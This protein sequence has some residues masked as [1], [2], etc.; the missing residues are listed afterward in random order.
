MASEKTSCGSIRNELLELFRTALTVSFPS[1]SA[2]PVVAACNNAKNGDYQCNNA[3]ALFGKLK[4]T[5]SAPKAPRDVATAIVGALPAN[6]LIAET[7][8]AGP[9][10]INIRLS[11]DSLSTRL[12]EMLVK[13]LASWAPTGYIGK[14]VVIDFSSPNVAKEMHVG[15]LR[16]TIIGDTL[17]RIFEYCGAD[18]LRLNHVGDWGTQF[19]ML[20]EH[21]ADAR[22]LRVA[23]GGEDK[24]MDEDVADL[25]ELYRAA[26]KRFDEEEEFK[27]RAREAVTRLQSGD[28]ESLASWQRICAASR[29]EFE[30]IYSRLGVTLQERGESFY[31]PMLKDVVEELKA[32]GVATI[33]NGAACVFV[34]GQSVPL[35]VQKSDGGFGYASTD[36]AAIKHRLNEE[37]ADWIIYVTDVGQSQHFELV[38]AAAKK[39]GWLVDGSGP[40]VSHVGFGLVLG[41][42]GKRF[43]TRSGDLVRLVELLDEAKSRCAA[44]IRERRAEA[45]EEVN[46][47][48]VEDAACAMG[49]GAVKYADLKNHRT[50]NYKFSFDEMLNLKGNTAVYL[51]YAHARIAGIVRKADKDVYALAADTPISLD[52]PKH[53]YP[54]PSLFWPSHATVTATYFSPRLQELELAL[55]L[56][57]L[58]EALEDAIEELAPNRRVDV[59]FRNL[60]PTGF[61]LNALDLPLRATHYRSIKLRVTDYLYDLSEKFNSFYVDCKVLGSEQEASRLLLC[62][63]TAVVMRKCFELLGIRPLYRI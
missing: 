60:V 63:A 55:H 49:Y 50:T 27:T 34:E 53:L 58:P 56:C 42:D 7:S 51:L 36:M 43:R 14:K 23:A 21:M 30:A 33:D 6:G 24:D 18:V 17:C 26:K 41:E 28:P 15:H 62:E 3:M 22:R 11:R 4:G 54:S 10:F 16:S 59:A 52:H 5:P 35:I 37:K 1:V 31:N 29:R 61:T 12:S 46:E 40:K 19:G 32:A 9:G 44:T 48:E 8:L 25:Q 45:G 20:I 38:F 2:E 13:G 47:A 39:A 57:K